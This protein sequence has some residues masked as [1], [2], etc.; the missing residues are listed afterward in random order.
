MYSFNNLFFMI[1]IIKLA[2]SSAISSIFIMF[3]SLDVISISITSSSYF[4][5]LFKLFY[6][7]KI[8]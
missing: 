6:R 5:F 7:L 8:S 3:L 4:T 1:F 2:I